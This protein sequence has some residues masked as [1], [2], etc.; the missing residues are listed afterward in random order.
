MKNWLPRPLPASSLPPASWAERLNI[1]PFLLD[2][3]W[4]RGLGSPE[5][6]DAFLSP[7][8]RHLA[9]P[10]DW[11]GMGHS[12]QVL[13]EGLL[14]GKTFAVW[15]DYDV[16]GVSSAAL[17]RDVLATHSITAIAYL[18]DRREGYGLNDASL[19]QLAAQGVQLLLT[20]DCGISDVQAVNRARELGICVVISDHHLP[21]PELPKAHAI[22]NPRLAD[23]PCPQL[24]GVGVAFFL[25][26]ALNSLLAP[27]T[28]AR[29][30]MRETLDLVAL[31]TLADVARLSGQ[32]RILVKNGL[33]KI[34]QAS[35]PGMAALKEI[36][37]FHPAAALSGSQVVFSL[38]PRLNAAGRLGQARLAFELLCSTDCD[39]ALN[40]ARILD[41]MN[42]QRRAEEER[43]YLEAS[44]QAREYSSAM[45]LVLYNPDWHPGIIGIVASRIVEDMYRP[46]LILCDDRGGLKGSGRSIREFDLYE[47]LTGLAGLFLTFGGHKLAAGV[48][49]EYGRL[50]ELRTRF[51]TAARKNLGDVP[52]TPS[53]VLDGE[54]SFDKAADFTLLKE[55]ELLQPF[56]SGNAEPVFSSPLLM[57]RRRR[58]FGSEKNHVVLEVEDTS[59]GI[60]LHAKAWRQ[61]EALPD[62]MCGRHIRLAYTPRMDTWNGAPSVDVRIK[63]WKFE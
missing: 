57:V 21:P 31:G 46:T 41:D 50:E 22:C 44:A 2:I 8:L 49:L 33:L 6:I 26:S 3:L 48:R 29:H 60:T 28:G 53:L 12:A 14:A 61:A 56:G 18:P 45:G 63:D 19:E 11:P 4:R 36:C 9:P 34:A 7:G 16:D 42:T 59:C 10:E 24:A 27:H 35:R 39:R 25:M 15:G 30:D 52:L 55:L 32:N 5:E 38:A 40:L 13:A 58:T 47:S 23:C 37:G 1:S 51:D 43:M 17:V 54:L 62:S 20:V